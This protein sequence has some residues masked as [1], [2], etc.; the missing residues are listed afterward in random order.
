[1]TCVQCGRGGYVRGLP[2]YQNDVL[3][4]YGI[5]HASSCM[6]EPMGM[7]V[8]VCIPNVY[9]YVFVSS[10]VMYRASRV[11]MS[12]LMSELQLGLGRRAVTT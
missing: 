7:N 3:I 5:D 6:Y 10:C 12:E 9:L 1:M 11:W 4:L 8:R 2:A